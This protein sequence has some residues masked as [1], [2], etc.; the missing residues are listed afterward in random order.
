MENMA[1]AFSKNL[2]LNIERCLYHISI[3]KIGHSRI[4]MHYATSEPK[5][6]HYQ[7][8]EKLLKHLVLIYFSLIYSTI[9]K[10]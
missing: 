2:G 3:K 6:E 4:G 8:N 1:S 9:K 10:R 7:K 5:I